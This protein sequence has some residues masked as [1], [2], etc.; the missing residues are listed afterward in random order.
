MFEKIEFRNVGRTKQHEI[1]LFE[2]YELLAKIDDNVTGQGF[3][4][5]RLTFYHQHARDYL[6]RKGF[7]DTTGHF[8]V[9]DGKVI[10]S[11]K[12]W[13]P[14]FAAIEERDRATGG[15]TGEYLAALIDHKCRTLLNTWPPNH[16]ECS[17][18]LDSVVLIQEYFFRLFL[19]DEV[20]ALYSAG[21]H[22]T[23]EANEEKNKYEFMLEAE[24]IGRAHRKK[25][26]NKESCYLKISTELKAKYGD[27]APGKSAIK[28]WFLSGK[29]SLD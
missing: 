16:N 14:L 18:V 27:I 7:D 17:A 13:L 24:T 2:F 21:Q 20:H 6:E 23:H 8:C 10:R 28:K 12:I 1:T 3:A 15:Q 29:I 5:R 26:K 19:L 9:T 22:R 25:G 4:E 11:D